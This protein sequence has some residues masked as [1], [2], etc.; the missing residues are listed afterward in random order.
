MVS[1]RKEQFK[2]ELDKAQAEWERVR[3]DPDKEL[4]KQK[5]QAR[6]KAQAAYYFGEE[7]AKQEMKSIIAWVR[8]WAAGKKENRLGWVQAM[9]RVVCNGSS[10]SSWA[11]LFHAFPQELIDKLAARTGGNAVRVAL[12]DISG[13]S[14]FNDPEGRSF[15]VEQIQGGEKQTF[16]FQYKDGQFLFE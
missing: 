5:M 12:P 2:S 16:L 6:R 8:V 1:E 13:L 7:R 3:K 4:R 11:I 9:N 14:I 15:L 10:K